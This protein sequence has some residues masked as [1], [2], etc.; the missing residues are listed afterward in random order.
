[1]ARM[2]KAQRA[3]SD[4]L[5]D[6]VPTRDERV[7][8]AL[9]RAAVEAWDGAPPAMLSYHA[10]ML[11]LDGPRPELLLAEREAWAVRNDKPLRPMP[12]PLGE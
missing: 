8:L 12:G 3:A 7:V 5:Y 1:M 9:W 4:A 10:A 11:M 2:T 6:A